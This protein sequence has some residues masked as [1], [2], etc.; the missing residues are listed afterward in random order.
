MAVPAQKVARR[1]TI[2]EYLRLEETSEVKHEFHD[3]H[4]LEATEEAIGLRH[5]RATA[6]GVVIHGRLTRN[7]TVAL[8]GRVKPPCEAF[9]SNMRVAV[10]DAGRFVYPDATVVCGNVEFHRLD[11]KRTTIINPRVICE[12]LSDSTESYDRG[13]KF[14]RYRQIES[15]EEYL[16]LAQDRPAVEGYLRQP[17]GSWNLLAWQG[18]E[19]IARLRCLKLELPIAELYAGVELQ[20]EPETPAES[21]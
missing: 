15:L 2:E 8:A 5:N 20:R 6:G 13:E 18:M 4:V 10:D 17:D 11:H 7:L 1:M 3:G 9:D 19:A 14:E 21:L 12:V 16:L